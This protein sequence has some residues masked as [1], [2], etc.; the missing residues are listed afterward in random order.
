[1]EVPAGGNDSS[2]VSCV[3]RQVARDELGEEVGGTS[4][5]LTYVA[6]FYSTPALT[7]EKWH[8]FLA[9][10]V[11]LAN[12]PE[13]ETTEEIKVEV[14]SAREVVELAR[15]GEMK[16]APCALAVLLCEPLLRE[17]GYIN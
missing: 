11:R 9:E 3:P 17:R 15:G 4:D 5:S 6:C 14:R 8:V 12:R 2:P 10:G 16:T 7:T 13:R 1:V